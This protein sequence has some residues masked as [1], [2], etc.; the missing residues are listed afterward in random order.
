MAARERS[1]LT[2][3]RHGR[4]GITKAGGLPERLQGCSRRRFRLQSAA[5][6]DDANMIPI[7]DLTEEE[8][9]GPLAVL[10]VGFLIGDYH[11]FKKLMHDMDANMVK[12]IPSTVDMLKGSLGNA[13]DREPVPEYEQVN[14]SLSLSPLPP[15]FPLHFGNFVEDPY[16]ITFFIHPY[17][18]AFAWS[19]PSCDTLWHVWL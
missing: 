7:E 8:V 4:N 5:G 16:I 10:L 17:R 2:S 18:T 19:T 13:L 14:F 6:Q 12:V 9:F 1:Y 11:A 3:F 15:P